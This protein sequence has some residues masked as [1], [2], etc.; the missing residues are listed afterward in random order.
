MVWSIDTSFVVHMDMK[1]HI[2]NFLTLGSVFLI[3]RP[4]GQ[5]VNTR[6]FTESKLVGVDDIIRFVENGPAGTVQ[7]NPTKKAYQTC[8]FQYKLYARRDKLKNYWEL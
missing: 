8:S 7:A 3:S 2:G 1:S 5:K 6:S 4:S